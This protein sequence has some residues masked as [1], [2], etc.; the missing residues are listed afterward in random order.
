M[1]RQAWAVLA[2]AVLAGCTI[3]RVDGPEGTSVAHVAPGILSVSFPPGDEGIRRLRATGLGVVGIE[4]DF[5]VGYHAVD[6]AHLPPDCAVAV[7]VPDGGDPAAWR[8]A[9]A[10]LDGVCAVPD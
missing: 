10:D 7:W 2:A 4:G 8:E 9:L 1:L 3:V 5:V 6:L